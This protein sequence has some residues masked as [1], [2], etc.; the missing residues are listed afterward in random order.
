MRRK[1]IKIKRKRVYVNKDDKDKDG[2]V[3]AHEKKDK[4]D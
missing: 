4:K 1:I 3:R 2:G